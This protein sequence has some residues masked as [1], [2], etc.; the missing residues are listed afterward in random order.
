MSSRPLACSFSLSLSPPPPTHTHQQ[1]VRVVCKTHRPWELGKRKYRP[2]DDTTNNLTPQF[3]QILL[4]GR[5][6]PA[7]GKAWLGD[8]YSDGDDFREKSPATSLVKT[9]LKSFRKVFGILDNQGSSSSSEGEA[10]GTDAEEEPL[11]GPDEE[12]D[13]ETSALSNAVGH[14]DSEG[15]KSTHEEAAS[16]L[17]RKR[18]QQRL[19][20]VRAQ[21]A[22]NKR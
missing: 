10:L 22:G 2:T 12:G 3:A 15:D 1:V 9:L 18:S 19:V 14:A 6:D 5:F 7:G 16:A 4:R 8:G 20:A 21:L 13:T 17:A 11:S